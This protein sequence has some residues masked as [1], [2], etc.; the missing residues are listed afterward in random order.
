MR[1]KMNKINLMRLISFV[2]GFM[3]VVYQEQ[4]TLLKLVQSILIMAVSFIHPEIYIM[5][6][7]MVVSYWIFVETG[8]YDRWFWYLFH[9]INTLIV[10]FWYGVEA[11]KKN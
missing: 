5:F 2:Y 10:S 9:S 4:S 6:L 8:Y 3:I 7:N 11:P 1:I